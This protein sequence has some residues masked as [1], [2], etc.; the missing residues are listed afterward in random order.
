MTDLRVTGAS[1]AAVQAA[2]KAIP[3]LEQNVSDGAFAPLRQWLRKSIHEIGCLYSSS[4]E[5]LLAATG[6]ELEPEVFLDYLTGKFSKLYQ[7]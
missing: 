1:T 3:D 7:V 4:D 2:K 6:K 5:L